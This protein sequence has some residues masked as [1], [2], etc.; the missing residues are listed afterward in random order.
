[1][2]DEGL[3]VEIRIFV[4]VY[5]RYLFVLHTSLFLVYVICQFTRAFTLTRIGL[6]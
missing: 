1:M 6:D 4:H 5:I 3:D 2:R